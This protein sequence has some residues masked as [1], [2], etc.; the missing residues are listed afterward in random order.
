MMRTM[1][2][3]TQGALRT[4]LELMDIAFA[5]QD[6]EGL[7]WVDLEGLSPQDCQPLLLNTF[8]FHPLAVDDALEEN[9][10]PKIDDWGKYL[11]IVLHSPPSMEEAGR[12]L[13]SGRLET[14]ELDLFL[15]ENYLVT[16]HDSPLDAVEHI[17]QALQRDPRLLQGGADHIL[18]RLVDEIATLSLLTV[19]ALDEEADALEA[20][21]FRQPQAN[22]VERIFTL[23][24]A[25]AHLRRVIAPQREVLNKLARDEYPLIDQKDRVYFRDVYDHYVRLYEILESVRDLVSGTLEIYLSVINNRLNDIMKTLTIITTFFMPISFIAGF[26]GMNFFVTPVPL[27]PGW[28]IPLFG[29][30]CLSMTITPFAMYLWMRRRGW[31]QR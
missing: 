23:K 12:L 21:V 5:L 2:W 3:P 11:Y 28:A 29:G 7:L 24:R 6:K 14:L 13:Q 25:M 26:F 10:L 31:M 9:H 22:L 18:Y 30:A 8:G 27:G 16:H 15:G 17:W 4:D 1:Y 20:Q 19:E